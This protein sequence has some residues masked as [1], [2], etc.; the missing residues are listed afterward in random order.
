M[1]TQTP[2]ISKHL[3]PQPVSPFEAGKRLPGPSRVLWF[4]GLFDGLL[5]AGGLFL[6]ALIGLLDYGTRPDFAFSIFYLIPVMACAWWG[7]FSHGTLVALAGSVAWC[8]ADLLANPKLAASALV[9]NG[10]VRFST[11]VLISSLVSRLH[12]G[13]RRERL[14]ARTDSLTGAA[15]GRTFYESAAAE[16]ERSQRVCRPL[17]LAYLDLDNFKL[18]NDRMGH[19][20]GDEALVHIVRV[21][22]LNLRASDLLARVGGDEFA[23]LLPETDPQGAVALL[24]RLHQTLTEEMARKKLP[25]TFSVGAIT[26]H[27]P[28]RD[29]DMMVQRVDALM[30]RVK[31]TGKGR[32]AHASIEDKQDLASADRHPVDRRAM[33]RVLCNRAIRVRQKEA[34]DREEFATL[35]DISGHGAGV[36]LETRFSRGTVLIIEPLSSNSRALLARVVRVTA[37]SGG[38]IH[39]CEFSLRLSDEEIRCWID[40]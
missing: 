14:L 19:A 16:A 32:V 22:H 28:L 4:R 6:V 9:F 12:A 39:G 20:A 13:I 11:L 8:L 25:I 35:R 37:E 24:D 29:V 15:N 31:K 26:F 5:V 27:R 1:T 21:I 30:Y 18:L 10:V 3:P 33:A 34:E 2:E 40:G 38:W 7:G 17:T 23:L 36:Y